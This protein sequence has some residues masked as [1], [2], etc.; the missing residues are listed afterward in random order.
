MELDKPSRASL[1]TLV[2]NHDENKTYI[3]VKFSESFSN[4]IQ[5]YSAAQNNN[6]TN[7]YS[8]NNI[9]KH[10]HHA[11]SK[12]HPTTK[13]PT[14]RFQGT[15]GAIQFP[16]GK[17]YDFSLESSDNPVE[18]IK[19]TKTRWETVGKMA[20][21]LQVKG[22]D[23]VYQMTR[24]KLKAAEQEKRKYCAKLLG[25][26]E[27]N[28]SISNNN[29]KRTKLLNNCN[30]SSKQPPFVPPPVAPQTQLL[31]PSSQQHHHHHQQHQQQ[32][33]QHQ[34]IPSKH[35]HKHHQKHHKPP[36]PPPQ[37]PSSVTNSSDNQY[38][39][40]V[41]VKQ[42]KKYRVEFDKN[43]QEY[44][45]LHNYLQRI[46]ERFKNLRKLLKQSPEGSPAWES[47]K[48]QIFTEYDRFKKDV[49]FH[50][51][52]N[53][54]KQLCNKLAHIKEKILQYKQRKKDMPVLK[55]QQQPEASKR[56]R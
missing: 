20:C 4:A 52:R 30:S 24:T 21:C 36:A 48:D 15:R 53:D 6:I 33:Q 44:Q 38:P 25:S 8:L 50:I 28:N 18:C 11:S 41:D 7:K 35:Q 40:I 19:Q 56:K 31:S 45:S 29:K 32:Q 54:Y 1:S 9:N 23:D 37:P 55:Q 34:K 13:E 10:H 16:D 47:A 26:P 49:N 5:E 27:H 22:K 14:I 51:A 43:F 39:D 12:H 17:K 42:F 3:L 2:K 46:E